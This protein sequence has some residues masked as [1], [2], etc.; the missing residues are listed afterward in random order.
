MVVQ[1][2]TMLGAILWLYHGVGLDYEIAGWLA[3]HG[4]TELFAILLAGA[5][6]H[7]LPSHARA[8]VG[9]IHWPA[10]G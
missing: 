6:L 10:Q 8:A 7:T 9:W 1:N 3:I 5:A 2:T 4:T